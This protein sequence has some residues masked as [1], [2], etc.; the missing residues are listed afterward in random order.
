M[1]LRYYNG[2]GHKLIMD[3]TRGVRYAS[4]LCPQILLYNEA[5]ENLKRPMTKAINK[6]APTML[7]YNDLIR[8]REGVCTPFIRG[9][10]NP[11][12][13]VMG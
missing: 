13:I 7:I 3:I 5:Y 8:I 12:N 1:G 2:Q 6:Q 10:G 4:F 11:H 9:A